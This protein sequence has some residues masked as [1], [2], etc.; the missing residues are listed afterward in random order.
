MHLVAK[1]LA[2]PVGTC[3]GFGRSKYVPKI[4][5]LTCQYI[6]HKSYSSL[7]VT[8]FLGHTKLKLNASGNCWNCIF[9]KHSPIKCWQGVH[10]R[11]LP[12]NFRQCQL[13]EENECNS[14]R[15]TFLMNYIFN[16]KL[17]LSNLI[18]YVRMIYLQSLTV[19]RSFGKSLIYG[20]AFSYLKTPTVITPI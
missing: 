9:C 7:L 18:N 13:S 5:S 2:I 11:I 15:Q 17:H 14:G 1:C 6:I 12:W 3:C 20:K 8:W 4:C 10:W 16:L 19:I